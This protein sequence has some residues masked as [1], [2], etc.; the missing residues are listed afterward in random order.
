MWLGLIYNVKYEQ[1]YNKR[2]HN[3]TNCVLVKNAFLE[4]LLFMVL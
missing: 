3:T 2:P 1:N 4:F